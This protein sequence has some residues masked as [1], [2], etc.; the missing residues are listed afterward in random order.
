MP[1]IT[2]STTGRGSVSRY[3]KLNG[4]YFIL[5][6]TFSEYF[7]SCSGAPLLF[8]AYVFFRKS[9]FLES[10]LLEPVPLH[11]DTNKKENQPKDNSARVIT[12][13]HSARSCSL[14][15]HLVVKFGS[16]KD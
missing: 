10:M 12:E 1:P 6:Q 5:E 16:S 3:S 14:G 2:D 13:N 8:F 11:G 7:A 9:M 4:L 15:V